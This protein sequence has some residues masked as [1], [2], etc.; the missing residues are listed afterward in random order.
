MGMPAVA[1][2]YTDTTPLQIKFVQ[3]NYNCSCAD[4]HS[5]SVVEVFGGCNEPNGAHGAV[6]FAE[7]VLEATILTGQVGVAVRFVLFVK[8]TVVGVALEFVKVLG[9]GGLAILVDELIAASMHVLCK[10]VPEVV[11]ML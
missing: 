9:G 5:C 11:K 7:V 2:T 8:G 3:E 6:S 4:D 1:T 10:Q